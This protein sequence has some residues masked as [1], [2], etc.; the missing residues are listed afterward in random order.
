M[1]DQAHAQ[2]EAGRDA[3]IALSHTAL[4][5]AS[6][7]FVGD[8]A[9]ITSAIWQPV[10]IAGWAAN[11][12][13]LLSLTVS[14]SAARRAIDVRR[15]A[16]ND[17]EPPENR[18]LRLLNATAL[19]SFPAALL[20]LFGFVTANVVHAHDRRDRPA[21]TTSVAD[22]LPAKRNGASSKVSEPRATQAVDRGGS[23]APLAPTSVA[24][25]YATTPCQGIAPGWSV[26]RSEAGS[27]K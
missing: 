18:Q 26:L 5:A 24:A 20:F 7:A 21:T 10:L 16:L 2:N 8:V 3:F 4:F 22:G 1:L 12:I 6:V 13:G 14:F 17:A 27:Q 11:V 23:S 9:P 15:A 25:T 19:W